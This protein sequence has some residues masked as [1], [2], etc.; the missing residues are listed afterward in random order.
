MKIDFPYKH[1]EQVE[2]AEVP[3]DD[4][5]QIKIPAARGE[6]RGGGGRRGAAKDPQSSSRAGGELTGSRPLPP[7]HPAQTLGK[8]YNARD[9][10]ERMAV[11]ADMA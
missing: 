6:S 8:D 10:L 2:P 9:A 3:D 7:L 5:L 1:Y 11:R 4:V